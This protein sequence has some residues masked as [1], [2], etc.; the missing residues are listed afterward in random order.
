MKIL[1]ITGEVIFEAEVLSMKDLIAEAVENNVS[2]HNA[3][4]RGADLRGANLSYTDFHNAN[5]RDADL[6]DAD[7]HNANL[8]DA[9]LR[10]ADLR[11]VYLY[12]ADLWGADLWGAKNIH[13][14]QVTEHNRIC[15]AVKH[16]TKV[17]FQIGCFW[18]DKDEAIEEIR[19]SYGK[20][21]SYE[22]LIKIYAKMLKNQS[23]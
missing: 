19:A 6:R 14:F 16:E 22:K 5:L 17:M 8:R 4:L 12:G 3:N 7:F 1:N 21:S 2:F 11:G 20:K 15:Y 10:G 23:C 18:G 13:L 9:N